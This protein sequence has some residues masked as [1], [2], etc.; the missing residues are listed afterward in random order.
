[1]NASNFGWAIREGFHDFDENR[2][3]FEEITP[4]PDGMVDPVIE[5]GHQNGNCSVT[6]GFW[7]DW[8]PESLRGGYL[9]GDFCS[10]SI[11]IA[12]NTNGVW[13]PQYITNVG[14]LIVGFGQGLDDELLIFSWSGAVY[15]IS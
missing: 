9:Y 10:G 11:W 7:M 1:M 13:T 2:G 15:Q 12:K 8:G 3:C 14:T 6:G 4:T 5:Y